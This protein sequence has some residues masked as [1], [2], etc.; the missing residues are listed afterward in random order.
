MKQLI[1]DIGGPRALWATPYPRQG[2]LG[3]GGKLVKLELMNEAAISSVFLASGSCLS[4]I[5]SLN[6][7][8]GFE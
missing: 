6:D 2:V 7:R 1:N 8:M 3:Y 5:T 4:S